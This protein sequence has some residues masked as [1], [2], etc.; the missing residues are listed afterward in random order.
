MKYLCP[1]SWLLLSGITYFAQFQSKVYSNIML[2][3][4]AIL[5]SL[6]FA[7]VFKLGMSLSCDHA[8]SKNESFLLFFTK[9][10]GYEEKFA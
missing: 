1:V 2:I 7:M 9:I 6:T 5:L 4:P 8:E 3:A 10:D